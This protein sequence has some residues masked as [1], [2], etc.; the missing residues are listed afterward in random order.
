MYISIFMIPEVYF[1]YGEEKYRPMT[2]GGGTLKEKTLM[3]KIKK[4][5]RRLLKVKGVGTYKNNKGT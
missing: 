2:M 4:N 1:Y 5:D 3:E